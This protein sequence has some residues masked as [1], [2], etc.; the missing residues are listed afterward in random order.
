[1][2]DLFTRPD[3]GAQRADRT[4]RALTHLVER[5][6]GTAAR[7]ARQVHPDMPAPHEVVRLVAG[8][9]GGSI[10]PEADEP[11]IDH[12]DLVAA[13]TLV[14]SMRADLDAT[15]LLLLTIARRSG[16]T[17]QDI[18][19]SLGLNTPQAARQRYERL[20]ARSEARPPAGG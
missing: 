11:A 12:D 2:P 18:A 5:H 10:G 17:W 6:A 16:M 9:A 1:M 8:L 13:L 3:S 15:E 7:R 14:P 19:F 4:Y 20:D